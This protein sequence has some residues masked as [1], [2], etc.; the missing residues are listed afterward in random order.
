MAFKLT[1][2]L[3]QFT[4]ADGQCQNITV[5]LRVYG[6][7]ATG[8]SSYITSIFK[9]FEELPYRRYLTSSE[10]SARSRGSGTWIRRYSFSKEVIFTLKESLA[11]IKIQDKQRESKR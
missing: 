8:L 11:K 6:D 5:P 7:F 3:L 1:F 2:F 4:I 10:P 9:P